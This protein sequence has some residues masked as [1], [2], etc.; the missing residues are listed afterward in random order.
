MVTPRTPLDH[1][2]DHSMFARKLLTKTLTHSFLHSCFFLNGDTWKEC[3]RC[4][5][6]APGLHGL[7]FGISYFRPAS[8]MESPLSSIIICA[9]VDSDWREKFWEK[10]RFLT[11]DI[12]QS[13]V[14]M[15]FHKNVAQLQ[16]SLR[17]PNCGFASWCSEV[18]PQGN[19]ACMHQI[20]LSLQDVCAHMY[21]LTAKMINPHKQ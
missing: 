12:I 20:H 5:H 9:R 7:G 2:F 16:T 10:I 4:V 21:K 6:N 18:E 17:L 8:C 3:N 15:R 1:N 14:C 19:A 13:Q 11:Q